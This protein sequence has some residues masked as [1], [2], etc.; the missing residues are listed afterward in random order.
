MATEDHLPDFGL[1][2][3]LKGGNENTATTCGF[4]D[5]SSVI[6]MKSL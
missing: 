4:P 3:D 1:F 5:I 6:Q 2:I